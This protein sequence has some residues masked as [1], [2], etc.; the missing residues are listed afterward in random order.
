MV[1]TSSEHQPVLGLF[2]SKEPT[3]LGLLKPF[4]MY[5]FFINCFFLYTS[6]SFLRYLHLIIL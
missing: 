6:S 3:V 5:M 1:L 4:F 2:E